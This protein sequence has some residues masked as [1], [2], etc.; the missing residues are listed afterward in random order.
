[1]KKIVL[2]IFVLII[3]SNMLF[4]AGDSSLSYIKKIEAGNTQIY[5]E[6]E[7]MTDINDCGST[8]YYVRTIEDSTSTATNYI[9]SLLTLS[10]ALNK[11]VIVHSK[12]CI[13]TRNEISHIRTTSW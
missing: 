4:A 5:L 3:G 6:L 8:K 9:L 2:S 10:A 7:S 11:P 1:M 13:G 12:T